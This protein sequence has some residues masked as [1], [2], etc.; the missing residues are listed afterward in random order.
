[1]GAGK[2]GTTAIV[3]ADARK[4]NGKP[5]ADLDAI[6][7]R[8][9]GVTRPEFTANV[10]AE[11]AFPL[12]VIDGITPLQQG[13]L[14][15]EFKLIGGESD[16]IAGLVFDLQPTGDYLYVRYNTRDD[17]VALW[18]FMKGQ[19]EVIAH[20]ANHRRLAH[21]RLASAQRHAQRT[22][23]FG[24]CGRRSSRGA[25]ARSRRQRPGRSLDEARF[26]HGVPKLARGVRE[27]GRPMPAWRV[28]PACS[29]EPFSLPCR[30]K[31][32]W[33][34]RQSAEFRQ[35]ARYRIVR[36]ALAVALYLTPAAAQQPS[37]TYLDLSVAGVVRVAAAYVKAYQEQL[38]FLIADE[39]Y[40]QQIRSQI[41]D[42][43]T[44]KA[45]TMKSEV[46]FMFTP[47]NGDWMA[48][49]DVIEVDRKPIT[50]R[51]DIKTALGTL[52]AAQVAG[53][54]KASNSRFNI[55]RTQRNFNE[56][57]LSLLVLDARYLPNFTFERRACRARRQR[58]P[59]DA[60]V[61]GDEGADPHS[62]PSVASGLLER[63]ARHRRR[64]GTRGRSCPASPDHR[65][66][67]DRT[68][69]GLCAPTN[70]W[71]SGC[72]PTSASGTRKAC[73]RL[74]AP[75]SAAREHA[76]ARGARLRSEILELQAVRDHGA[77]QKAA[78][79]G[80]PIAAKN[81]GPRSSRRTRRETPTT[82]ISHTYG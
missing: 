28:L 34:A 60:G 43:R 41:P 16:Q 27:S 75:E 46:F 29:L 13:T 54:S 3:T 2:D 21:E 47:A 61:Y 12:A 1:M 11:G 79:I 78:V 25:H 81:V 18:R 51:Q 77:D 14:H 58:H 45:R 17:N 49:R 68:H 31:P 15:V 67:R 6:G 19:R 40:T 71:A 73:A 5:P 53:A 66:R 8:L 72:R 59:R 74:E 36:T 42:D 70:G 7:K 76:I 26:D 57:I 44:P 52:P 22:I 24:R 35:V 65:R 80:A 9:F 39:A 56:P 33:I 48:I 4:W 82:Y 20:G 50:G 55:G 30:A 37:A 64:D 32:A 62:R 69:H 23:D 38:T 10:S 63:R